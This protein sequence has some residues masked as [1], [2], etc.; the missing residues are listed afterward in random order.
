MI[1]LTTP[2]RPVLVCYEVADRVEYVTAD[3]ATVERRV[4]DRFSL[5]LDIETRDVVGFRFEG[6]GGLG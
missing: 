6:W 4:D 5:L 3:V 1:D 2:Y